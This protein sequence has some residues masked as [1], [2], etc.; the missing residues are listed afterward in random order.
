MAVAKHLEYLNR[1]TEFW[2]EWRTENPRIRPVL[3]GVSLTNRDFSGIN[4]LKANLS[5]SDLSGSTFSS[6]NCRYTD[7][8]GCSLHDADF[9]SANIML[10]DLTGANLSGA[11]GLS[12][13]QIEAALTDPA[14]ELPDLG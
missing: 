9:T 12:R 13:T 6:A 14:T 2:N 1:G 11:K 4:F 8:S 10:A 5:G 3:T 7:F